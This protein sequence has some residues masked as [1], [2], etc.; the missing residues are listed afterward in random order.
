VGR[1]KHIWKVKVGD[2]PTIHV[3]SHG[4]FIFKVTR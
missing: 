2:H 4:K 3:P 1:G